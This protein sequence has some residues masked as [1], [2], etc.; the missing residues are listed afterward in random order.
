MVHYAK[1]GSL[2]NLSFNQWRLHRDN[3]L[4]WKSN[5]ALLHRIDIAGEAHPCEI[6]P[7]LGVV[8]SGQK[9]LEE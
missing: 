7:E 6:F 2:K 8:V 3:R 5:F 9:L 1:K 4:V